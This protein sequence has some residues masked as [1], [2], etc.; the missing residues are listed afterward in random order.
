M[1]EKG[2]SLWRTREFPSGGK[3]S[4]LH[5]KSWALHTKHMRYVGKF[6]FLACYSKVM[7]RKGVFLEYAQIW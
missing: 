6:S 7:P 1:E 4:V 3:G 2:I 5:N